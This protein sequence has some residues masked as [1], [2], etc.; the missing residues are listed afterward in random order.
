MSTP[1]TS[2]ASPGPARSASPDSPERATA[3]A[4]VTGEKLAAGACSPDG[5]P[6]RRDSQPRRQDSQ[7]ARR[8][9]L[10]LL[11]PGQ[12]SLAPG[13]LTPW[14]DSLPGHQVEA[15]LEDLSGMLR[16]DLA[17]LGTT[18]SAAE[19][20]ATEVAQPL[21]LVTSVLSALS[22][23]LA[24]LEPRPASD[25]A[26]AYASDAWVRLDPRVA[27]VAGHSLGYLTALTLIGTMPL[28]D[29]VMIARIRGLAMA[30]CGREIPGGMV[31]LVGGERWQVREAVQA[32]GLTL[33]NVNGSS[34]VVASGSLDALA[35][36]VAPRGCRALP[37]AV[38]GA[39][40][41][42]LMAGA[43]PAVVECARSLVASGRTA[44]TTRL[45]IDDADAHLYPAGSPGAGLVEAVPAKITRPVRWDLVSEQVRALAPAGLVELAPAGAL[46]GLARRDLRG[47]PVTRLRQPGDGVGLTD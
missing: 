33:A 44:P 31:A 2:T 34:Q 23:G 14:L 30:E 32:A 41:S 1:D 8:D 19:V 45:L 47:I 38:S 11:A 39:F 46:A 21:T 28:R 17:S 35:R 10:V 13:A 29:A 24:W 7:A 22:A 9:G 16:L 43:V 6:P 5:Q 42:P 25:D 12:G 15:V 40:H 27:A 18:A 3:P 37:L 26:P 36:L 20:T 4:P